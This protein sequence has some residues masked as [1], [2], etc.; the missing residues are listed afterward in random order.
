MSKIF[1]KI[2]RSEEHINNKKKI[3]KL[4]AALFMLVIAVFI[5]LPVNMRGYGYSLYREVVKMSSLFNVRDLA[6]LK[7][8][9][10]E[11]KYPPEVGD[12]EARLVLNT[13]EKFYTPVS[14]DYG[15]TA[16]KKI[17]IIIY[18]SKEKLN[19]FF[20]WPAS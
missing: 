6:T 4:F 12:A 20:G 14:E 15:F 16:P 3:I 18:S 10:F 5:R 9:H 17:P 2:I 19:R 8:T 7:G 13:A 11:V 1:S